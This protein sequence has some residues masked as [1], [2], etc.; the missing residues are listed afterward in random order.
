M[1]K[2]I[3]GPWEM[4]TWKLTSWTSCFVDLSSI[5]RG[6]NVLC[7]VESVQNVSCQNYKVIDSYLVMASFASIWLGSSWFFMPPGHSSV[8]GLAWNKF[9]YISVIMIEDGNLPI[10]SSF[11]ISILPASLINRWASLNAGGGHMLPVNSKKTSHTFVIL[12][13]RAS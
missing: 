3:E 2:S 10:G 9:N 6:I 12:V 1:R 8:N 4:M 7:W 13:I 11:A 5:G